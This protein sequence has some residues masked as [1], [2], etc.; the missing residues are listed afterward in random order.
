MSTAKK[1]ELKR[2]KTPEAVGVDSKEVQ[3]L[4]DDFIENGQHI[5]SVMILRHGKVACEVYRA[6][7]N[8][9]SAHAM[10][11]VSKSI[12]STAIGFAVSE[13]LVALDTPVLEVFPE[14]RPKKPDEYLEKLNI[15]HLLTMT[16]G[17][18]V[19]PLANKEKDWLENFFNS[20][21]YAQPGTDFLYVNE[22]I[23]VLCAVI[24]RVT[25]VSVVE[26]LTP[27]LFEPL[28][29][30]P[31]YWETCP[32]GIEAGG[33]GLFLKTE[34]L[35]KIMLTYQQ[36]GMY[37]GRR[38]LPEEWVREAGK[39][40][41]DSG[42]SQ[43]A[44]D[45]VVGYGYCFW[46]CAGYENAYRADGLF[47]QFGI[48]FEDLDACFICTGGDIGT[49][50]VRNTIW[51]H[52]PACFI[53]NSPRKKTTPLSIPPY[54]M[55]P[56]TQRS[57]LE[58]KI[59]G[60]TISFGK[61]VVLNAAGFPTSVITLPGVLM[62]KDRA[63]NIDDVV[64]TFRENDMQMSWAE[65]DEK[66]TV[67]VGLD[68]EYRVTP[69]VLGGMPYTAYSHAAW[70]EEDL[71]EVRIRLIESVAERV[72]QFRFKGAK[73][74]MKPSSLP[75]I[76][77]IS[78]TFKSKIKDV[79]KQP[80]IQSFLTEAVP[81]LSA[82]IDVPVKGTIA[83]YEQTEDEAED[84]AT[85]ERR[86]KERIEQLLPKLSRKN[87]TGEDENGD[88]PRPA[89][90][91]PADEQPAEVPDEEVQQA[92][93]MGLLHRFLQVLPSH[94]QTADTESSLKAVITEKLEQPGTGSAEYEAGYKAALEEILAL[95]D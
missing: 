51:K 22:N 30:E 11:S 61:S 86:L 95:L 38:I 52:V 46:R 73:V 60:K 77:E 64:F 9:G 55:L 83:D 94:R 89:D 68:G 53:K 84:E 47:S 13:G 40:H 88:E 44:S 49:Q 20:S 79:I 23:Y 29:I 78:E 32:R 2:A 8:S 63:G 37:N 3:A 50:N 75:T 66:N 70:V 43:S 34:D 4:I 10:Y 72:L 92:E 56:V 36:M 45:S 5:H 82:V 93:V 18:S 24:H 87:R 19:S 74:T 58:S 26:Y 54:E 1:T 69:I 81:R 91:Q 39:L 28:G 76:Q 65:G 16:S 59:D 42:Q 33:W 80:V 85:Q 7:F 62:E 67:D 57:P 41:S 6:P 27:R 90:E 31:P 25:G 12:T 17:K 71:L 15:S 21:W 48:V 14:F 35:A